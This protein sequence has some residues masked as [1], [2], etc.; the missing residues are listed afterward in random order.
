MGG[1]FVVTTLILTDRRR[2]ICFDTAPGS[3][4]TL[5]HVLLRASKFEIVNTDDQEHLLLWMPKATTPF[6]DRDEAHL[7][8]QVCFTMTLPIAPRVGMPIERKSKGA[9]RILH[10]LPRLRPLLF[11]KPNPCRVAPELGLSISLLSVGLL[12]HM[13]RQ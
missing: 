8:H 5:G 1:Y 9:D 10:A 11:G 2:V 13:P 6:S 3:K 4:P 12:D 7:F